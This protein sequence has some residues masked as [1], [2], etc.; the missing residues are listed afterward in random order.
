[1]LC[2]LNIAPLINYRFNS[3]RKH[4]NSCVQPWLSSGR[5]WCP[6]QTGQRTAGAQRLYQNYHQ[7][8]RCHSW[9]N[10]SLLHGSSVL[11]NDPLQTVAVRRGGDPKTLARGLGSRGFQTRR[12][13]R[14][15][16]QV[17]W[18]ENMHG[19][20]RGS[21]AATWM[22]CEKG[23]KRQSTAVQSRVVSVLL[24]RC[25]RKLI[26]WHLTALLHFKIFFEIVH[27]CSLFPWYESTMTKIVQ[28]NVVYYYWY[29]DTCTN[30]G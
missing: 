5:W 3:D 25:H 2:Y 13:R 7:Q 10:A 30:I 24:W 11:Q 23:E 6:S 15:A 17:F 16:R 9:W 1:M 14:F 28:W 22:C 8:N 12:L 21:S 18:R 29:Y 26:V 20:H 19:W 27:V 4:L